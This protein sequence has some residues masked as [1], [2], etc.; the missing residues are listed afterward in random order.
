MTAEFVRKRLLADALK[1]LARRE[2][3]RHELQE[4]L[5]T[6]PESQEWLE[7]VLDELSSAGWLSDE[8]AAEALVRQ[9]QGRHGILRIR[10]EMQRRGVPEH[11]SDALLV[12]VR[13][14]EVEA[15]RV[16]WNKKFS[17]LPADAKERA[18]QARYLQNRGFSVE[19]IHK[20]LRSGE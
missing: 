11:V 16:V 14:T 20:V 13:E 12:A 9:H 17:V 19:T 6:R 18:R 3:T 10:H 5:L 7:S 2:H 8:R 4:K 1:I 15:A